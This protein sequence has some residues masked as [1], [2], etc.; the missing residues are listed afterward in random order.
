MAAK[1][2][3]DVLATMEAGAK[4]RRERLDRRLMQERNAYIR[5]NGAGF[6]AV[7]VAP[8]SPLSGFSKRTKGTL[9]SAVKD[10]W[11]EATGTGKAVEH[12]KE[13]D[14][15]ER[16]LQAHIIRKAL[17]NRGDLRKVLGGEPLPFDELTFAFDEVS[18]N[19]SEDETIRDMVRCDLLAVGKFGKR[20]EPV[21][22]ELKYRLDG[23]LL[24]VLKKQLKAFIK[25]IGTCQHE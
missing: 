24:N 10:T 17:E 9:D 18:L 8:D 22:I 7:S 4:E 12:L 25:Q 15:V 2:N 5:V 3:L 6:R 20:Y 16:S 1:T 13:F 23:T 21:L 19:R 11:D 14:K